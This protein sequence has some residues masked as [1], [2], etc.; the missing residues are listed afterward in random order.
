MFLETSQDVL[1]LVL[2]VSV[3]LLAVMLAWLI[4]ESAMVLRNANKLIREM[5]EKLGKIELA[6]TGIRDKL[7]NSAGYL[8]L[9][10]EGA[11][12][13]LGTILARRQEKKKKK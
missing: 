6:I 2:S 7:E 9:L 11:K 5:R 4:A 1:Y 12:Q 3:L 8:H 10:A 13:I